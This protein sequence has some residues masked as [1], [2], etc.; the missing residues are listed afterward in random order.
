MK[1][2]F[3][4]G[5]E[6]S[7]Y[8]TAKTMIARDKVNIGRLHQIASHTGINNKRAD[9]I[10]E[11]AK[12][13]YVPLPLPQVNSQPDSFAVAECVKLLRKLNS[14]KKIDCGDNERDIEMEIICLDR[15]IENEFSRKEFEAAFNIVNGK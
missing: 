9:E 10:F 5:H 12:N 4:N 6:Q 13:D 14:L 3:Q 2:E 8:E 15:R 7:L 11:I 1:R